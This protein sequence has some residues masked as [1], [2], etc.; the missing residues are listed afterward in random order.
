MTD[1]EKIGAVLLVSTYVRGADAKWL[2][3]PRRRVRSPTPSV[4]LNYGQ[5][6]GLLDRHRYP[7]ISSMI[8][9]R[10]FDDQSDDPDDDFNF[11]LDVILD[12]IAERITRA[13]R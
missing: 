3:R 10:T 13:D 8:E 2:L 11:G 5:L 7:T 12:G 6:A 9:H 4:N 1:G